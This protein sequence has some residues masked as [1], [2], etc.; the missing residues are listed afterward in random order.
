MDVTFCV[1]WAISFV[2]KNFILTGALN[3]HTFLHIPYISNSNERNLVTLS[4]VQGLTNSSENLP[5]VSAVCEL[6]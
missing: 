5:V 3:R 4:V 2:V 6:L 1:N